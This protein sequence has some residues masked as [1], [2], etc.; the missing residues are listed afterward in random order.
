MDTQAT[1]NVTVVGD[2]AFI[3]LPVGRPA[4]NGELSI[5]FDG[6][7][8][9]SRCPTDVQCVWAGN[10]SIRLTLSSGDRTELAIL[11]STLAPQET[12][13]VGYTIGFRDLTPY[14]VSTEPLDP[15][16]YVA[17]IAVIDTR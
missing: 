14:P 7:S 12:S 1:P 3:E 9:D 13:F 10:A 16:E 8:E 17:L 11:N 5:T 15:A 4:N 6:I 2:T